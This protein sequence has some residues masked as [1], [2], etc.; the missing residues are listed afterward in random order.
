[1]KHALV[2]IVALLI[3]GAGV[4]VGQMAGQEEP[5]DDE[6]ELPLE[7][8]PAHVLDAARAAVA[9]VEFSEA[10]VEA[11]L[12]Y[13]LEGTVDGREVEIEVTA[14]GQVIEVE[15]EEDDEEDEEGG[16]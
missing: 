4:A 12:V 9:G 3:A 15:D 6:L 1:M 10:E 14:E 11:V 8:I 2:V 13:E 5:D 16:A 7:A